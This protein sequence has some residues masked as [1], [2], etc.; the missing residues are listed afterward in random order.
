[1]TVGLTCAAPPDASAAAA[2]WE[3]RKRSTY[4]LKPFVLYPNHQSAYMHNDAWRGGEGEWSYLRRSPLS[5]TLTPL[6]VPARS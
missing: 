6:V 3:L 4:C 5:V 1:M 2:I